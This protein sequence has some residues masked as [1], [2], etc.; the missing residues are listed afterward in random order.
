MAALASR[1][2]LGREPYDELLEAQQ[3][4]SDRALEAGRLAVEEAL[5]G[6]GSLRSLLG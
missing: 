1:R 4:H 5:A 3:A 2:G 6:I